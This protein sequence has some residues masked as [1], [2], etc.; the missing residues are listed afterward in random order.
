[1]TLLLNSLTINPLSAEYL[2]QT[3]GIA[4]GARNELLGRLAPMY[5]DIMRLQ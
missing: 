5:A 3:Q 2:D 4:L 1:M